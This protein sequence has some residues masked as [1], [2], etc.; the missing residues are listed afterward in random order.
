MAEPGCPPSAPGFRVRAFRSL[1]LFAFFTLTLFGTPLSS[2]ASTVKGT[3]YSVET[4]QPMRLVNV[5]VAGKITGTITDNEGFFSIPDIG[6]DRVTL[7]FSHIGFKDEVRTVRFDDS[8]DA[9]LVVILE[10]TEFVT[11]VVTVTGT[12]TVKTHHFTPIMVNTLSSRVMREEQMVR[13]IPEAL[14]ETAGV[15][16]QKTS[17]GQ[18]S[19]YIRGFTGF[20][21]VFLIDGVRLNNSVYREGPNQYWN[22]VDVLSIDRL[23]V[24]RGPSSVLYGSDAVGGTVNA[25]TNGP[26]YADIGW[27]SHRKLYYRHATAENSNMGRF[28]LGGGGDRF[29]YFLGLS[30]KQFG[31]LTGGRT[32]GTQMNTGYGEGNGDVKFEYRP[33]STSSVV[34]AY[35]HVTQRDAWRTHRTVYGISW[36]GTIVG[37]DK[38]HSF[39]QT[40]DL[41]YIQYRRSVPAWAADEMILSLS[42]H[43]QE[44]E[45]YRVRKDDRSD[46]QGFQVET[47][48]C[49]LQLDK[50][51]PFGKLTYGLE[52]YFDYVNSFK[53]DY[54]ADG[55]LQSV[56]VQGPVADDATYDMLGLFVQDDFTVRRR[57]AVIL[58]ARYSYA[59]ADAKRVRN[60]VDGSVMSLRDQWDM[61]VGNARF[62]LHFDRDLHDGLF[63]SIS[64]GFRA[65]NLSD[66]TRFDTARSNEIETAAPGLSPEGFVSAEIGFKTKY[67]RFSSQAAVFYT[68]ISGMIIRCPTGNMIDGDYEVTKKNSGDGYVTGFEAE[69]LWRFASGFT[70]SGSLAWIEGNAESYP[71]SEIVKVEEP[72]SHMMPATGRAAIRW[73]PNEKWWGEAVFVA[74]GKQDELSA[75]DKSDTQRIPPGGTPGYGLYTVRGG[76]RIG[77]MLALS[78]ALENVTDADYRIHGSGQNEAGRGLLIEAQYEF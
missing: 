70:V 17:H 3:V 1:P 64:Q 55:S 76:L 24:A 10:P 61:V 78:V 57:L 4:G 41:A 62:I 58:G 40:R 9:S 54:N 22:T 16:V 60:P 45:R 59:R 21:N 72:I 23:D 30:G 73:E 38:R 8:G 52:Y 32:V 25:L 71:S 48:G 28:E 53:R 2:P 31:D 74:A 20:R 66:L 15:M 69:A 56:D 47:P 37:D 67:D 12:R 42:F 63:G 39:D 11:E 27:F 50:N 29:G 14:E 18:G 26:R 33:D 36:M 65:P 44:E 51:G 75:A 77:G 35:Q 34:L 46:R 5:V 19:P 49:F 13:T 7:V 68:D 43:N 6:G